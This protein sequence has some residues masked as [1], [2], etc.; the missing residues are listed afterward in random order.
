[1]IKERAI[2]ALATLIIGGCFRQLIAEKGI[3]EKHSEEKNVSKYSVENWLDLGSQRKLLCRYK[4]VPFPGQL[5]LI[6][7]LHKSFIITLAV[8]PDIN[9]RGTLYEWLLKGTIDVDLCFKIL[10][11]V[12]KIIITYGAELRDCTL[13]PKEIYISVA[14]G[15]LKVFSLTQSVKR[16]GNEI[17][18]VSENPSEAFAYLM[19]YLIFPNTREL[20]DRNKGRI[21]RK[22]FCRFDS[23]IHKFI[24]MNLLVPSNRYTGN[25]A[26]VLPFEG[27]AV[28]LFLGKITLLDAVVYLDN[29]RKF[30]TLCSTYKRS[31]YEPDPL[32]RKKA[33]D[34]LFTEELAQV[35]PLIRKI[36]PNLFYLSNV[37]YLAEQ[38]PKSNL[39]IEFEKLF[40]SKEIAKRKLEKS[41]AFLHKIILDKRIKVYRRTLRKIEKARK[42]PDY[43]E[44]EAWTLHEIRNEGPQTTQTNL[45]MEYEP[46]IKK[47]KMGESDTQDARRPRRLRS[48]SL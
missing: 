41:L 16:L 19:F 29:W 38:S 5:R 8:A 32:E 39:E 47:A 42:P 1:M 33:R 17:L 6:P 36:Y 18:D 31:V 14:K 3:I 35:L 26:F 27:C 21:T 24:P 9:Y 43:L 11:A 10:S 45:R 12:A 20:L 44:L 40:T 22:H 15:K 37:L 30:S 28:S 4:K 46:P 23:E 7:L 34:E 13:H 25:P 48:F 2:V